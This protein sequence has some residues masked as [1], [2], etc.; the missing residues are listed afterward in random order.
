MKKIYCSSND[1]KSALMSLTRLM[2]VDRWTPDLII[3]IDRGGLPLGVSL[4]HYYECPHVPVEWKTR[5]HI[6]QEINDTRL[7]LLFKSHVNVLIVDDIFDSGKT[8]SEVLH[9]IKEKAKLF[10]TRQELVVKTACWFYNI[11]VKEYG[12]PDYHVKEINKDME[13]V[14]IVFPWENWWVS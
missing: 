10:R 1:L 7:D 2:I 13:D 6:F 12:P 14:W 4:S 11:A 9:E 5:D 8:I 3:G